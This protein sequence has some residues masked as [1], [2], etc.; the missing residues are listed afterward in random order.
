M[1]DTIA[2]IPPPHGSATHILGLL[3]AII[4]VSSLFSWIFPY[5]SNI[6]QLHPL[7]TAILISLGEAWFIGPA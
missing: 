2:E 1:D 7:F 3:Q 6:V 4:I 5:L